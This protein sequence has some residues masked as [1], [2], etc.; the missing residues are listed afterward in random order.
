MEQTTGLSYHNSPMVCTTPALAA[1]VQ[2]LAKKFSNYIIIDHCQ[3]PSLGL[4]PDNPISRVKD[5][6]PYVF[7][8]KREHDIGYTPIYDQAI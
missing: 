1:S 2:T 5:H 7:I 4:G 8:Q 6:H 3:A